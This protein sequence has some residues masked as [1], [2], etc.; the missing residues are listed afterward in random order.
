VTG[1]EE[2][3]ASG[4][5]LVVTID[6]PAG[7][8]KSTT[9]RAVAE[10][11]GLRHL[12]SGALYRAVTVALLERAIPPGRW[13]ELS[14]DD[15]RSLPLDIRAADSGFR[16]LYDGRPLKEE[17]REGEVTR[18]VSAVAA[19]PQ[20]RNRLLDLQRSA[21]D[22]GGLVADGR[23]MGTVV[24]PDADVKIFLTADLEERAR[25]RMRERVE[26]EPSRDQ[27]EAEADRIATRDRTDSER[28][29]SPLRRPDGAVVVDTTGAT[30]DEQVQ[31][32]VD[33]VR[34]VASR[35]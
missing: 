24:F 14:L 22:R 18:H 17:L 6:G 35:P 5:D 21:A 8:G 12:D 23:D 27:V 7:S 20:V 32:V 34:R 3:R 9:A 33:R 19:L 2:D 4:D 30:F 26:G 13:K 28:E 25:R 16:V 10:R 1:V 31:A 11:L 15:L 29:I